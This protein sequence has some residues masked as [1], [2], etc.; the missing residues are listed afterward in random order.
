MP[1]LNIGPGCRGI[2]PGAQTIT[3]TPAALAALA[4]PNPVRAVYEAG[5]GSVA[6]PSGRCRPSALRRQ[7]AAISAGTNGLFGWPY[8]GY[9]IDR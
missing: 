2:A 6:I 4:S 8:P 3:S 7:I 9:R 1:G 5:P